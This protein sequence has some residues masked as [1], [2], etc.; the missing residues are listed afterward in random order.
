MSLQHCLRRGVGFLQ[1]D[2]PISEFL[3][4]NSSACHRTAHERPGT[5]DPEI[6]VQ[7][8]DLGLTGGW[9]WTIGAIEQMVLPRAAYLRPG[10][11]KT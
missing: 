5:H 1:I 4:R 9:G 6:T 2:A 10:K 3:E 8:F 7:I 11:A